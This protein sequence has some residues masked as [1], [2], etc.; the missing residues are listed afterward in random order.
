MNVMPAKRCI[1]RGSHTSG[2]WPRGASNGIGKE[3]QSYEA[4]RE[5]A[6]AFLY[7]AGMTTRGELAKVTGLSRPDAGLGNR[8]L[9]E[10]GSPCGSP[11]AFTALPIS[12]SHR[13]NES[14]KGK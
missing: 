2:R 11:S 14:E 9:V 5:V 1:S 12:I 13:R 3:G 8:A 6:R 7:V 4:L 10:E